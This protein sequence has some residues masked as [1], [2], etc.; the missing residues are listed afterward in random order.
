MAEDS[1]AVTEG[2]GSN[3]A[4]YADSSGNYRQVVILGDEAG[5]IA[6]VPNGVLLTS[7]GGNDMATI[8]AGT[9]ANTVVKTGTGR[10]C[11]VIVTTLGTAAMTFYDNASTTSGTV[12]GYIPASAAAGTVY[13]FNFP[14]SNG[15]VASGNANNPAVTITFINQALVS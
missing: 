3:I 10:L 4:V 12:I 7:D 1:L 9:V 14:H 5:T 15:I 8:A 13:N 11:K 2:S 6:E